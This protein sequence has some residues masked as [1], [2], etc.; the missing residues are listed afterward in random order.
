MNTATTTPS[1]GLRAIALG[2][3]YSTASGEIRGTAIESIAAKA[4]GGGSTVEISLTKSTSELEIA[5]GID[6]SKNIDFEEIVSFKEKMSFLNTIKVTETSVCIVVRSTV[7][8]P[9]DYY[10]SPEIIGGDDMEAKLK[11]NA[12]VNTFCMSYG[13][14]YISNVKKGAQFF[15]VY[16][17]ECQSQHIK[18]KLFHEITASGLVEG[19]VASG[20]YGVTFESILDK[21]RQQEE[22][23]MEAMGCT[24]A[25]PAK[26]NIIDIAFDFQQINASS[27]TGVLDFTLTGYEHVFKTTAAQNAF[28][29]V[30]SNRELLNGSAIEKGIIEKGNALIAAKQLSEDIQSFYAWYGMS[31]SNISTQ[32]TEIQADLQD[33]A[34]VLEAFNLYPSEALPFVPAF[35]S[36]KY[37]KPS[38][39]CI[40]N[41]VHSSY[42]GIGGTEFNDFTAINALN[43]QWRLDQISA[44]GDA[45]LNWIEVIYKNPSGSTKTISH[46]VPGG[47]AATSI[48]LVDKSLTSI[49]VTNRAGDWYQNCLVINAATGTEMSVGSVPNQLEEAYLFKIGTDTNQAFLGF[50]GSSCLY[51][52]ALGG[53]SVEFAAITWQ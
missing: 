25:I 41:G 15:C 11:S 17:Y 36:Y 6:V 32:L 37:G 33:Y 14:A 29:T 22:V 51:I 27:I 9:V 46:G 26:K 16:K 1:K 49:L 31:A 8:L 4:D 53:V 50:F 34:K 38:K 12:D 28:K 3:G 43:E 48:S 13:D 2:L 35:A 44:S 21:Y 20:S 40:L 5:L 10:P 7:R 42:G 45:W 39:N 19:I 18:N 24:W 47:N 30:R 52:D 23:N